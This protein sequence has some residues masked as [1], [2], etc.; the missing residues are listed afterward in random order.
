MSRLNK[1][2]IDRKVPAVMRDGTKLYGDVYRPEAEGRYPVIVEL[3]A[4]ELDSR[5]ANYAE[6]YASRGYVFVGMNSRGTYWSE[7]E[8]RPSHV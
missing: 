6:W 2:V 8:W 7:G 1:I 5:T 4:Y 3:V